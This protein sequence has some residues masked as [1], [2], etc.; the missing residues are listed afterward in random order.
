MRAKSCYQFLH[1]QAAI[2]SLVTVVDL[3]RSLNLELLKV[4]LQKHMNKSVKI[5]LCLAS[6]VSG[7]C[8]LEFVCCFV[9]WWLILNCLMW[10][11]TFVLFSIFLFLLFFGL[12]WFACLLAMV[13]DSNCPRGPH[14][15][16]A[17][18]GDAGV[19]L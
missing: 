15:T 9:R 11:A 7:V 3:T 13:V 19:D 8:F 6:L 14:D 18:D 2:I 5:I 17:V 4:A 1:V 16:C 12:M 10:F